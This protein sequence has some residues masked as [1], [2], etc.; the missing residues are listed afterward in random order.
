[1]AEKNETTT[2]LCRDHQEN[3]TPMCLQKQVS[4]STSDNPEIATGGNIH[5]Q[6]K[7]S[8]VCLVL[9]EHLWQFIV[10]W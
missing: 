3:N 5:I 8:G 9:I 1:M 7:K 10:L 6:K 2:E 4:N